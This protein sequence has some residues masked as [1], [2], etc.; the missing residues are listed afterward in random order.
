MELGEL[1]YFD[2]HALLWIF[3]FHTSNSAVSVS[4]NLAG[5]YY[6]F[7]G[8]TYALCA[9][10]FLAFTRQIKA[11]R[12]T[13][14]DNLRAKVSA[15]AAQQPGRQGTRRNYVYADPFALQLGMSGKP[16]HVEPIIAWFREQ[17]KLSHLDASGKVARMKRL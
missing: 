15:A 3:L 1:L 6:T 4:V 16:D 10:N 8:D 5:K 14:G 13:E 2:L 7:F 11:I 12:D 9:Q 17:S